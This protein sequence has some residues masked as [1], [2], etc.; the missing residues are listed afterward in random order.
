[1][2]EFFDPSAKNAGFRSLMAERVSRLVEARE[3]RTGDLRVLRP[4]LSGQLHTELSSQSS[5]GG[6]RSVNAQKSG[7]S[8]VSASCSIDPKSMLRSMACKSKRAVSALLFQ[9][10]AERLIRL[11][12]MRCV[13]SSSSVLR[14]SSVRQSSVRQ[15]CVASS[16][17]SFR[18]GSPVLR[19]SR[20][21]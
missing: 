14:Q 19:Q 18:V 15:S 21:H 8:R 11:Q 6:V 4:E 10:I 7:Q 9:R 20:C 16:V 12:P 2:F 13:A 3:T 17:N 5:F 1:M